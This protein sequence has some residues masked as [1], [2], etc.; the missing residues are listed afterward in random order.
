M[1]KSGTIMPPPAM[2]TQS[3]LKKKFDVFGPNGSRG[4]TGMLKAGTQ[5]HY[6]L[7]HVINDH[8]RHSTMINSHGNYE[9]RLSIMP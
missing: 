3:T 7:D 6:P 4:G 5:I 2:I 1:K 8:R 9:K